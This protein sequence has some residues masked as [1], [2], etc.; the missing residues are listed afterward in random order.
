MTKS[1]HFSNVLEAR[2][3]RGDY[4]INGLPT[5]GE[6]AA[7]FGV[8]RMTA[9]RTLL[10]LMD[11]GL[12]S[13]KPHGRL[14]INRKHAGLA[15]R[16]QLACLTPA[17][18]SPD[19]ENWRFAV[20]RAALARGASLRVLDYVHWDDPILAQAVAEFD[21]VFVVPSSEAL[22]QFVR[23]GFQ[24]ARRLVALGFDFSAWGIPSVRLQPPAGIR[25]LGDHL[26]SLGHRVIDCL[27]T[28]PHDAV[29][30]QR[31]EQWRFWRQ[32][33]GVG[34]SL[35]DAPVAPYA[36]PTPKAHAAMHRLLSSGAFR[37]TAL[38]CLTDP[39]TTGAIRAF[40]DHGWEVGKNVSVCT[41]E[42]GGAMARFQTPSVTALE[43]PD[44]TPYLDVCLQ[45]F[46]KREGAWPGPLLVEP[47]SV[48]LFVGESTGPCARRTRR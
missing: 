5:E 3:A 9:R 2:V 10:R 36:H 43:F 31:L 35:I 39:P 47:D 29:I 34:G 4:A 40:R 11:K 14:T 15:N 13:R 45:W 48:H 8:S 42:G 7:E 38:I 24:R 6:L 37:A 19:F 16:M 18:R 25:R 33:R 26:F 17:Y 23:E 28:Q 21:G 22:P 20:E 32:L 1:L 41:I 30:E 12:L 27:N 44:P 46:S